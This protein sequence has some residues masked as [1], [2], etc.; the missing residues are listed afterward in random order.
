MHTV[1]EIIRRSVFQSEEQSPMHSLGASSNREDISLYL[2]FGHPFLNTVSPCVL[3]I[4]LRLLTT[5]RSTR[6]NNVKHHT[7]RLSE[8]SETNISFDLIFSCAFSVSEA[9]KRFSRK[10][11]D[12]LTSM[13]FLWCLSAYIRDQEKARGSKFLSMGPVIPLSTFGSSTDDQISFRR[14]V[15]NA[16]TL[17]LSFVRI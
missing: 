5:M 14:S 1:G 2:S 4:T 8:N 3:P 7:V 11:H 12:K 17:H 9:L 13:T 15:G 16:G 10:C 6:H